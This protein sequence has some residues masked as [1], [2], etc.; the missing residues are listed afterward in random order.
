MRAGGPRSLINERSIHTFS[1]AN[2]Y[3]TSVARKSILQ[4]QTSPKLHPFLAREFLVASRAIQKRG[5]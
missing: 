5:M 3:A 4:R 1:R 2:P